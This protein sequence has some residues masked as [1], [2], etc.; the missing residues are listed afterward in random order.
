MSE[1]ESLE[2]KVLLRNAVTLEEHV[3]FLQLLIMRFGYD[4]LLEDASKAQSS[5]HRLIEKIKSRELTL[6]EVK[7]ENETTKE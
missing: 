7:S 3:N 4:A 2:I 5:L 6:I 1:E